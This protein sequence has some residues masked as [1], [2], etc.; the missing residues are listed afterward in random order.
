MELYNI[1][2]METLIF[3]KAVLK[4]KDCDLFVLSDFDD[5]MIRYKVKNGK[6]KCWIKHRYCPAVPIDW[7]DSDVFDVIQA[8]EFSNKKTW[9]DFG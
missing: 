4:D 7:R 8:G 5:L 9:E 6:V 1:T 3:D 2:I